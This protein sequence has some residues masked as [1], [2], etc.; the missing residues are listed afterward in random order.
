M[1]CYPKQWLNMRGS[2]LL[3]TAIQ[4]P[5]AGGAVSKSRPEV[6]IVARWVHETQLSF[7]R[8]CSYSIDHTTKIWGC[9]LLPA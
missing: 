4:Q 9:I 2:L 3:L 7:Q 6:K 1:H 8:R 5:Q